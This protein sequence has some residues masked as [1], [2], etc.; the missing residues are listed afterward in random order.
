MNGC[1]KID[2]KI[3]GK[4][5]DVFVHLKEKIRFNSDSLYFVSEN[6]AH[7]KALKNKDDKYVFKELK[8]QGH[9]KRLSTEFIERS[10]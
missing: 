9:T 5:P 1:S 6:A 10:F 7:E 4:N 8:S 3:K 2:W